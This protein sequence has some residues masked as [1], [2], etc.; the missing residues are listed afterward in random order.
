MYRPQPGKKNYNKK[1]KATFPSLRRANTPAGSG[2]YAGKATRISDAIQSNISSIT[3]FLSKY[4]SGKGNI[5]V[6]PIRNG[7]GYSVGRKTMPNGQVLFQIH[8]PHWATYKLPLDDKSKYRIYRNG[9]W[10]EGM[11]VRYTPEMVYTFGTAADS[12]R[13]NVAAAGRR[14]TRPLLHDMINILEDRRIEDK[15]VELWTGYKSERLFSNAYAWSRRTNVGQFWNIYL[16]NV[17]DTATD[18]FQ[19]DATGNIPDHIQRRIGNFRHEA[20]LQRLLVMKIKGVESIPKAERDLIEKVAKKAEQELAKLNQLD[21]E[22]DARWIYE[23]LARLTRQVIED[24]DLEAYE[25]PI[26]KVGE[27]SWDKT[28]HSSDT[29]PDKRE[30]NETRTGIDDYFDELMTIEVVCAGCGNHYVK[31]YGTREKT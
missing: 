16:K 30:E 17:Y 18:K 12:G 19:T 10:H 7:K 28:F 13:P 6:A 26:T 22:K 15:G 3:L 29:T 9:V 1:R 2:A 20:F 25:P 23:R 27:S 4:L 5:V 24:L 11:H 14:V 31:K 8:V 21:P